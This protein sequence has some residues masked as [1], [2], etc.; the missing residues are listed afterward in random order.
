M[1]GILCAI[2]GGPASQGP[3][4]LGI[5]LAKQTGE[6]LHFLF[7]INLD[8]LMMTE[9]SRTHVLSEEMRG[10]G[11]FILLTAQAKAD[12]SGVI[13]EGSV[14]QG[15]VMEEIVALAKE[16][17]VSHIILGRP[18]LEGQESVF[19]PERL[20][21]FVQFLEEETGSKVMLAESRGEE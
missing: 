12:K 20:Q 4:D 5:Q 6:R 11:E 14:R 15:D 21:S 10:L 8:F 7:V 2:R 19:T 13:A 1:S 17:E 3:I 16:L 9:T 18:R